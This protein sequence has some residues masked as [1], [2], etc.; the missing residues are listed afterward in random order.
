MLMACGK[1]MMG[2][3]VSFNIS[4]K[5]L[6]KRLQTQ[7]TSTITQYHFFMQVQFKS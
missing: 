6:M 7:V 4:Q 2:L 5:L 3:H 1:Q